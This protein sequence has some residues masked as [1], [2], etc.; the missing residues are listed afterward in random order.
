MDRFASTTCTRSAPVTPI[1]V[2]NTASCDS[3]AQGVSRA[4][5]TWE[6]RIITTYYAT[7]SHYRTNSV[8]TSQGDALLWATATTM[9]CAAASLDYRLITDSATPVMIVFLYNCHFEELFWWFYQT[10][11]ASRDK[12]AE[13]CAPGR[14]Q[15]LDVCRIGGLRRRSSGTWSSMSHSVSFRGRLECQ[16]S[17]RGARRRISVVKVTNWTPFLRKTRVDARVRQ[18]AG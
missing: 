18:G 2:Q 1:A 10:T 5:I 6:A 7:V 14:Q 3:G 4:R 9:G 17:C 12:T 15:C 11:R 16:N 13:T 8:P